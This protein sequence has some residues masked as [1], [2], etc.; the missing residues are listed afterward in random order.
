MKCLQF[1]HGCLPESHNHAGD[2]QNSSMN[3]DTDVPDDKDPARLATLSPVKD[4]GDLGGQ[5][6]KPAKYP[7]SR[8]HSSEV[9]VVTCFSCAHTTFST[10]TVESSPKELCR[11]ELLRRSVG[12][13]RLKSP[14]LPITLRFGWHRVDFLPAVP[15]TIPRSLISVQGFFG[16][17]PIPGV[18]SC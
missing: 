10:S 9:C 4:G 16:V 17:S 13:R 8:I 5:A 7:P 1:G 11:L 18:A 15:G 14:S 2:V 3:H 6:R 12:C